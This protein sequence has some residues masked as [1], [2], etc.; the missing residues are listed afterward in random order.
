VDDEKDEGA[1][2]DSNVSYKH[3]HGGG[4]ESIKSLFDRPG[5]FCGDYRVDDAN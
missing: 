2:Q 4:Q 1:Q 5:P 3:Q